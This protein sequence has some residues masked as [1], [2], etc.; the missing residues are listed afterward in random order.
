VST[1]CLAGV[2]SRPTSSLFKPQFWLSGWYYQ[3]LFDIRRW[4]PFL[5]EQHSLDDKT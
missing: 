5:A 2:R 1:R 4:L 3:R